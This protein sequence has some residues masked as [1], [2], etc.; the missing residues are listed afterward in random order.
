MAETDN[1][2][3]WYVA[4]TRYFRHEL[5]VRDWLTE[6]GISC[7]VP[8]IQTRVKRQRKSG[9][10]VVEK[11]AAPNLVFVQSTKEDA[12]A[13]VADYGLPMQFLVDC[14]THRMMV[15]PEKQM[16]DFQRVFEYSIDEG[17]L[18]DQPLEVGERVRV[19]EGP[20]KGVEGFVL[21]LLGRTYVLVS[22]LDFV[23]AKAQIPRAFLQKI[24]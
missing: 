15:V 20:L 21:E 17:G 3:N 13:L 18:V 9:T 16:S 12:C 23:W 14:A 22:L 5:K 8:T 19:I 10:R 6:R 7:Y 2:V 4:R 11:P 24:E 1:R